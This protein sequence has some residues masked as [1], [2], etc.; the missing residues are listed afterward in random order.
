MPNNVDYHIE[1]C[2][3]SQNPKTW[4]QNSCL[5]YSNILVKKL[6]KTKFEEYISEFQY[7]NMNTSGELENA[8][9]SSSLK[10]SPIQQ[11]EFLQKIINK[12]FNLSQEAYEYTKNLMFIQVIEDNWKLY[13]KTGSGYQVINNKKTELKH[14]WFVG[15]I[16]KNNQ[17]IV[18]ASHVLNKNVEKGF[19]SQKAKHLAINNLNDLILKLSK[20]K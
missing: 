18:F 6:T 5:W 1:K 20:Q 3:T 19:A 8:W 15:Y 10:I 7:G 16:E 14:G 13:G 4:I 12:E 2:K 11:I 17:Q 9:I